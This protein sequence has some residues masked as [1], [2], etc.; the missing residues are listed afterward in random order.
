MLSP[1]PR[2]RHR[3]SSSAALASYIESP[4]EGGN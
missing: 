4:R 3:T 2:H 1:R